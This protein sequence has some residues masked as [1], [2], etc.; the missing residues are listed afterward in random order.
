MQVATLRNVASRIQA[1][2]MCKHCH[3][4]VTVNVLV[5]IASMTTG[6]PAKVGK[7][8]VSKVTGT[9]VKLKWTPPEEEGGSPITTYQVCACT[10]LCMAIVMTLY[11]S[12]SLVLDPLMCLCLIFPACV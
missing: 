10:I 5:I 4:N 7:P 3:C 2:G 1:Y 6:P 12:E 9:S 11:H 8:G